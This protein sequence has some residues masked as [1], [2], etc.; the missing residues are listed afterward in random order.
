MVD[1]DPVTADSTLDVTELRRA[2]TEV[3]GVAGR[4]RL[5]PALARRVGCRAHAG[6]H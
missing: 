1:Q 5:R 2:Y 3:D 6:A 4:R